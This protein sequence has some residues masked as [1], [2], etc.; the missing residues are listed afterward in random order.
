MTRKNRKQKKEPAIIQGC[1][2]S[3]SLLE[4]ISIDDPRVV[5]IMTT[6]KHIDSL[7]YLNDDFEELHREII[8][9]VDGKRVHRYAPGKLLDQSE[10][11]IV[12]FMV[13]KNQFKCKVPFYKYEWFF[14]LDQAETV[15]QLQK[16]FELVI[17]KT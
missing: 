1:N 16:I 4:E 14:T 13:P 12:R 8:E 7:S 5:K 10:K 9:F 6:S 3:D 15:N 17:V 2:Q 11:F